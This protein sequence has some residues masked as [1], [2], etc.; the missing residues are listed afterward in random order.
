MSAACECQGYGHKPRAKSCQRPAV[1]CTE[2]QGLG[3]ASLSW[4]CYD[5]LHKAGLAPYVRVQR[6]KR[7]R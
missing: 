1:L 6:K 2:V 5:R 4:D 3:L 7:N